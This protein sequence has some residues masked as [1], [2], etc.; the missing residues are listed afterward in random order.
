MMVTENADSRMTPAIPPSRLLLA[1]AAIAL[2]LRAQEGDPMT[3]E[4][5]TALVRQYC[6]VCHTDAARN[7]GLTLQHYNAEEANPPLAAMLLSKLRN[8]AMGAAGVKLPDPETRHA[9]TAATIAQAEGATNWTVL[10]GASNNIT[11]SIIREA[12]PRN[13]NPDKPIYRLQISCNTSTRRGT[14]Q[15][16]WSPEPQVDRTFLVTAD[17]STG[18][19]HQLSG[20]ET[21][22]GNGS[23]ATTGLASSML[24]V[25]LAKNTITIGDLF[26]GETIVFPISELSPTHR[27]ELEPCFAAR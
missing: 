4:K 6:T 9:W 17:T 14:M 18:I 8:G 23:A 26:P 12:P 20:R 7:G 10:R 24:Q 2:P 1:L 3:A 11:A 13:Q 25:P 19:P 16:T 27:N 15:L 21:K 5:Q 22:M